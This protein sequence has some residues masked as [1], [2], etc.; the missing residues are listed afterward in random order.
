MDNSRHEL[1]LLPPDVLIKT[2]DVDHAHWNHRPI[3]GSI[4]RLRF[5]LILS[6]LARHRARALLE[7]GYGS[8]VFMSDLARYCDEL[9][10]I[11]IHRKPQQVSEVLAR[12]QVKASLFT[13]CAMAMPFKENFFDCIVAVSA[14]EF[15][16]DLNAACVEIKRVLAPGGRFLVVTP[17]R[18][19]IADGGLR[20]LTGKKAKDDFG[21]RREM[22]I[23]TL[24]DHFVVEDK[25]KAPG[26]GG[27]L[28]RLY[29]AL[30]LR[31][32]S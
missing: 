1:K 5:K 24:L 9:Y 2:G 10:G 19:L 3:L 25:L 22:L 23:P 29:T 6:L 11:D 18:S 16:K 4:S 32:R 12:F 14:L 30:S 31:A 7:I 28:I 13:G 27:S 21:T 15:I 20:V 26:F 17:G 8:G